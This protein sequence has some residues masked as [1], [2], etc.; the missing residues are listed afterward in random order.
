VKIVING[1]HGGFGLSEKAVMR[2]AELK[3]MKIYAQKGKYGDMDYF[4][5]PPSELTP[6][7][8]DWANATP[9]QRVASSEAYKREH[10]RDWN[11]K[12][13][14]LDLVKVVE[15]MGSAEASGKYG[16]LEVV[17]IPD[18]V[19]WEIEEYDGSEW[20]S[21]KHRTWR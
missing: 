17:E 15:E 7:L 2:Y 16:R 8:K 20:V 12:R 21:E 13:D 19:D 6:A 4:T 14:D 18:G 10:F 5:V 11:I 9:E 3:G 1:C